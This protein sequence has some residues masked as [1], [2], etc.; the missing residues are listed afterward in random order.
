MGLRELEM[1][2]YFI[3]LIGFFTIFM[4]SCTYTNPGFPEELRQYLPY[5][6][7]Q[8][9]TFKN[10]DSTRQYTINELRADKED[11]YAWNCK[12]SRDD[13]ALTINAGEQFKITIQ[14]FTEDAYIY[15]EKI[16]IWLLLNGIHFNKGF[17]DNPFSETIAKDLG[18]TI[19]LTNGSDSTIIVRN[20]GI[21]KYIIEEKTWNIME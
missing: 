3:A 11:K 16:Q 15:D 4:S 1:N 5:E 8:V 13:A 17:T 7:G 19:V 20:K 10:A 6:K 21:I 2:K 9:L 18:D 12:C 14:A